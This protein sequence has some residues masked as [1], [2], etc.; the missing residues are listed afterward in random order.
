M[1]KKIEAENN[2]NFGICFAFMAIEID[3]PPDKNVEIAVKTQEMKHTLWRYRYSIL[4]CIVYECMC[5]CVSVALEYALT[6]VMH[7]NYFIALPPKNYIEFGCRQ[8]R[9]NFTNKNYT[10]K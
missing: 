8:I 4:C 6:I 7:A 1:K 3:R 9:K 10:K 2:I 5:V